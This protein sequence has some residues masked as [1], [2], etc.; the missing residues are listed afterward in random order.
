[1]FET[2]PTPTPRASST[3]VAALL[4]TY[5]SVWNSLKHHWCQSTFDLTL[6][7]KLC[8]YYSTVV[9][10]VRTPPWEATLPRRRVRERT[11]FILIVFMRGGLLT[12]TSS[13]LKW[14]EHQLFFSKEWPLPWYYFCC[15]IYYYEPLKSKKGIEE[16]LIVMLQNLGILYLVSTIT[17]NLK[18]Y[19]TT[20]D[21]FLPTNICGFYV[22]VLDETRRRPGLRFNWPP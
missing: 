8:Y 5:Y 12:T 20:D 6:A 17:N 14:D 11:H 9:V 10:V 16:T 13:K 7:W 3:K 18:R 19:H 2:V 15:V 1:M 21:T 4:L 22:F